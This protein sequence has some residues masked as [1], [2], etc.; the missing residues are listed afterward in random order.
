[1]KSIE[2]KSYSCAENFEATNNQF[3][4]HFMALQPRMEKGASASEPISEA[5]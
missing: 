2:W 4:A 5:S 1:M 3:P